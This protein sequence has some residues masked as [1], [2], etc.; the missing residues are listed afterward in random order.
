MIFFS[1]TKRAAAA[2][3][4][5]SAL[6]AGCSSSGGRAASGS[7]PAALAPDLPTP[8][9]T[10]VPGTGG[11][12][13]TLPMGR[14]DETLNT[15]WQLF[16]HPASASAWSNQVEA[17]ATATNG[18]L[19]L[20]TGA[21]GETAVGIRPSSYLVFTPIVYTTD[22]GRTWDTGLLDASLSARP[23]ALA[24]GPSGQALALASVKGGTEVLQSDARLSGWQAL[25]DR[26][27]LAASAAGR[28]CGVGVLAAV[29]YLDSAPAVGASC[30]RS[31]TVG[32][33]A[34]D[35][36]VWTAAGPTLPSPLGSGRAEV[37]GIDTEGSGTV[38]LIGVVSGRDTH[39]VVG[40]RSSAGAWTLT[41]ALSLPAGSTLESYGS[42]G[43]GVEFIL[44]TSAD[45]SVLLETAR[46]SSRSWQSLPS[47]PAGTV[48]VASGSTPGGAAAPDGAAGSG[49]EP[50]VDALAGDATVLTVWSLDAASGQ[51]AR[52]QTVKVPIQFGSSGQ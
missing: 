45:G 44:A 28:A 42:L 19:V 16:S 38:A 31:G 24:L 33:F 41:P 15:F 5:A 2:A 10:S 7:D 6:L 20:A 48:T 51:W 49:G 47:P 21:G 4:A 12:W 29:G 27:D 43:D 46:P 22:Q 34:L 50:A 1:W 18:G 40:W 32:L 35:D 37:L 8:M 25:A 9:V 17:T 13:A 14:L 26:S 36:G 3:L 52:A 23:D 30:G 11:V 39:L